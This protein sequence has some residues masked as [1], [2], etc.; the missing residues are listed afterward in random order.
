[1]RIL[2]FK[3]CDYRGIRINLFL[4]RRVQLEGV[5]WSHRLTAADAPKRTRKRKSSRGDTAEAERPKGLK[6]L[7][8]ASSLWWGHIV[9]ALQQGHPFSHH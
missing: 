5:T 3:V 4:E 7:Q 6:V 2:F 1:M 9:V 8:R